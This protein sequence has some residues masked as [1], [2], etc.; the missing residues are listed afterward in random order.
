M[1][2]GYRRGHDH[3]ANGQVRKMTLNFLH[4]IRHSSPLMKVVSTLACW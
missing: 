1:A 4:L 3:V 2:M